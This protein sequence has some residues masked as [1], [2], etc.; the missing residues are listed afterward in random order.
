MSYLTETNRTFIVVETGYK[1]RLCTSN[2]ASKYYLIF[3]GQPEKIANG[4]EVN[5]FF[6]AAHSGVEIK[7]NN[8]KIVKVPMGYFYSLKENEVITHKKYDGF[9]KFTKI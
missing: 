2:D 7:I 6:L 1:T 4:S 8:R 9:S 5:G 3:E